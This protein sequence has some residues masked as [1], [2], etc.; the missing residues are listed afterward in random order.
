MP[1]IRAELP[2][3]G[4]IPFDPDAA[5]E[6]PIISDQERVQSLYWRPDE[7]PDEGRWILLERHWKVQF[8]RYGSHVTRGPSFLD[9]GPC[10]VVTDAEARRLLKDAGHAP[11]PQ[12]SGGRLFFD[13]ETCTVTLDGT[14]HH[15]DDAVVFHVF[16]TIADGEGELV[17]SDDIHAAV[18]GAHA[19]AWRI[20]ARLPKLLKATIRSKRGH[21]GGYWLVLPGKELKGR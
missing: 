2:G 6:Y 18:K 8:R 19:L 10:R 21:G 4:L 12:V 17:T 3:G 20:L 14:K 9:Y 5:R 13:A 16:K 1:V 7:E 15:V 11:P